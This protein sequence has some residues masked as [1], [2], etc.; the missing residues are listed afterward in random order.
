M[1]IIFDLIPDGIQRKAAGVPVA[2]LGGSIQDCRF[3]TSRNRLYIS[4]PLVP[5]DYWRISPG[6]FP[7]GGPISAFIGKKSP[8]RPTLVL[9]KTGPAFG[10]PSHIQARAG[11]F[12]HA[13]NHKHKHNTFPRDKLRRRPR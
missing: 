6:L 9:A 3:A 7:F 10:S 5:S 1:C 11:A 12:I 4:P 2:V 13:W 8:R